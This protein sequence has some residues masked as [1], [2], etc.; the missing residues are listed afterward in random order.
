MKWIRDVAKLDSN[1]GHLSMHC[2]A[3]T[4]ITL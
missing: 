1:L 4:Y 2:G 3:T